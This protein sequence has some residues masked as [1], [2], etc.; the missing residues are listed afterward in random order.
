MQG[1]WTLNHLDDLNGIVDP[2]FRPDSRITYEILISGYNYTGSCWYCTFRVTLQWR[3][4]ESRIARRRKVPVNST[5][6]S[7][8]YTSLK[9]LSEY[10]DLRQLS[11]LSLLQALREHSRF[12]SLQYNRFDRCQHFSFY[13]SSRVSLANQWNRRMH[14]VYVMIDATNL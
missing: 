12:L 5:S 7:Y 6:L 10:S 8:R 1:T 2:P 13:I 11:I 3:N 9:K 4:V 14:S